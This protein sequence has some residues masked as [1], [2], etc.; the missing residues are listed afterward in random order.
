MPCWRQSLQKCL[1]CLPTAP[2]PTHPQTNTQFTHGKFLELEKVFGWMLF[3]WRVGKK[4]FWEGRKQLVAGGGRS[5]GQFPQAHCP[6]PRQA[7]RG[8]TAHTLHVWEGNVHCQHVWCKAGHVH[9]RQM[10][11][12][13]DMTYVHELGRDR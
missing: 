10:S 8:S 9:Q 12:M 3:E 5:L 2:K 4:A 6:L 11:T 7:G 1:P 13:D